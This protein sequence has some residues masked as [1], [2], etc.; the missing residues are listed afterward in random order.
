MF[1]WLLAVAM[2]SGPTF[3]PTDA[4]L[5]APERHVAAGGMAFTWSIV[6]EH[7]VGRLEAPTTGWVAVGF[8]D[9]PA[10]AG[11]RLV[12]SAVVDGALV[13]EE[14]VAQPPGHPTREALGGRSGLVTAAGQE[15]D[16]RTTVDLILHLDPGDGLTPALARGQAIHLTLA[17]SHEDDFGHHSAMR[18]AVDVRL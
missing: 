10:L 13:I 1:P 2:A 7:L 14:H 5:K 16:G 11:S 15:R 9:E 8:N 6:G 3:L 4:A 18:T 17:W 12:M